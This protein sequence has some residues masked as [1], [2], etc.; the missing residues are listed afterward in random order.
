[1]VTALDITDVGFQKDCAPIVGKW[2]LHK[3]DDIINNAK[4]PYRA[5]L[6]EC[7]CKI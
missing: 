6:K 1:M 5:K 4:S 3:Q 2:I 7:K